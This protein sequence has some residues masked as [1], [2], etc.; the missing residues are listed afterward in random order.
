GS[1]SAPA[2]ARRPGAGEEEGQQDAGRECSPEA[3]LGDPGVAEE[4]HEQP[5]GRERPD[6]RGDDDEQER[7]HGGPPRWARPRWAR[8][9]TARRVSARCPRERRS[10]GA[11]ARGWSDRPRGRDPDHLAW[12][13][14]WTPPRT[15]KSWRSPRRRS[16]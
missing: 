2:A 5:G 11:R 16:P 13:R 7:K 3:D 15:S 4:E 8:A 1:A 14:A 6:D 9:R 12:R 10:G